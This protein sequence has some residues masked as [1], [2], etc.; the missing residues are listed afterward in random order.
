MNTAIEKDAVCIAL[1]ALSAIIANSYASAA[2]FWIPLGLLAYW[3][4]DAMRFAFQT[5]VE[6]RG[7]VALLIIY[8]LLFF[9]QMVFGYQGTEWAIRLYGLTRCLC[10]LELLLICLP[11]VSRQAGGVVLAV[12][13]LYNIMYLFNFD[14]VTRISSV[15]A[16]ACLNVAV[17]PYSIY[18]YEKTRHVQFLPLLIMC[19][20][21]LAFFE[22]QTYVLFALVEIIAAAFYVVAK[23]KKD[24]NGGDNRRR[25]FERGVITLLI[26]FLGG[27]ILFRVFSQELGSLMALVNTDRSTIFRYAAEQ[28]NARSTEA[29]IFGT[30]DNR[31]QVGVRVLAGHNLFLEGLLIYGFCGLLLVIL[32]TCLVARM[33]IRMG[34]I[35]KSIAAIT[36]I[37]LYGMF[38]FHPFF[39]TFILVKIVF[40]V[41]L[42]NLFREPN[43]KSGANGEGR[44]EE[45]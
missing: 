24:A 1:M 5:R 36:T 3:N 11:A 42:M 8:G 18:E 23:R 44:M 9:S 38:F 33:I 10:G 13:F 26:L 45:A 28:F 2:M 6:Y 19:I 37:G 25:R 4:F 27:I 21:E 43:E 34:G 22:S 30:G 31:V 14:I 29:M 12:V 35:E 16:V 40:A 15:N 32:E 7:L 39:S 17:I 20:A 41:I